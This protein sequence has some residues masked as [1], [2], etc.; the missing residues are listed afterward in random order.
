MEVVAFQ[1]GNIVGAMD[2][3]LKLFR[4]D[5]GRYAFIFT[6]DCVNT[7]DIMFGRLR[8]LRASGAKPYPVR[9]GGLIITPVVAR[10]ARVILSFFSSWIIYNC[11]AEKAENHIKI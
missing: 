8:L 4:A 10:G 7:V 11:N 6:L 3:C 2:A 9:V 5:G 1:A